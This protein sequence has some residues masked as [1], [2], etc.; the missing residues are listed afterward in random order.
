V[1]NKSESKPQE[2]LDPR[3]AFL[4]RAATRYD[5]VEAGEITIEEAFDGLGVIIDDEVTP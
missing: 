3:E 2:E 5:L 4:L 1:H